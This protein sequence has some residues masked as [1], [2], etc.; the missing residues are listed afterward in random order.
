MLKIAPFIPL[1]NLW[2]QTLEL[3]R[4]EPGVGM[5]SNLVG[6]QKFLIAQGCRITIP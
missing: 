6:T 5:N 1:L 3:S 4:S 2:A